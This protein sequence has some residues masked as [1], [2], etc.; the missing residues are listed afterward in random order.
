[1]FA[2]DNLTRL[3]FNSCYV[4]SYKERFQLSPSKD[5][6]GNQYREAF[7]FIHQLPAAIFER[8]YNIIS[9]FNRERSAT[10]YKPASQPIFSLEKKKQPPP[11][12]IS[13]NQALKDLTSLTQLLNCIHHE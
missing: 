3:Q 10:I 12:V 11:A 2:S 7:R 1:M 13:Q 6:L 5:H 8:E 9:N 4:I